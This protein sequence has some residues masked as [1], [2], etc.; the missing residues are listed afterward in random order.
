MEIYERVRYLRKDILK[1]TQDK[2][3]STI[4][5]KRSTIGNI[6][7]GTFN[8]TDQ[9]IKSICREFGVRE[10]WLRTGEGDPLGAQT[11]NQRILAFVNQVLTD[12]DDS[13][14]KRL[15]DALTILDEEEWEVLKKIAVN[16]IITTR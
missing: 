9:S 12:E 5:L 2:F 16:A 6:E 15:V 10:D 14:R 13:F 3:A 4:G 11:R 7:K 8:I 1:I